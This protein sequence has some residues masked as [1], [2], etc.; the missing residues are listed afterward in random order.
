VHDWT[1]GME[2]ERG[3]AIGSSRLEQENKREDQA[4]IGN[5]EEVL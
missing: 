1:E 5:T 2:D 3:R 4:R